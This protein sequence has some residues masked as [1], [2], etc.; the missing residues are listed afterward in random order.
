[1]RVDIFT[2]LQVHLTSTIVYSEALEE[3]LKCNFSF[4]K[5]V[6]SPGFN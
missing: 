4:S 3:A 5:V 6:F 1:M 2:S